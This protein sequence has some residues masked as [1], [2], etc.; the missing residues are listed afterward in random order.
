VTVESARQR[1]FARTCAA[2]G[3]RLRVEPIMCDYMATDAAWA[4]AGFTADD[5]A[6]LGCFEKRLGRPL[7]EGDLSSALMNRAIVWMIKN[8]HAPWRQPRLW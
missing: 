4:A 3:I 1:F 7:C 6:C 2:C 5:V 8:G